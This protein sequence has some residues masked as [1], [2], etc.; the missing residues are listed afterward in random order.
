MIDEKPITILLVDDHMMVRQGLVYFLSAL[1][2]MEIIG[3]A[4]TGRQAIELTE[5][6]QP[7]VILMDLIL[8]DID[9]LE[10]TRIIKGKYPD[11]IAP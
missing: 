7:Q 5:K 11:K 10:A 9:G 3:Q 6:L 8:P 4:E 2:M 1:P